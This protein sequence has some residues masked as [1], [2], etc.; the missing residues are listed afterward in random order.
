M[1]V[2][3]VPYNSNKCINQRLHDASGGGSWVSYCGSQP[4][5]NLKLLSQRHLPI[6]AG[7]GTH[8]VSTPL[9]SRLDKPVSRITFV[10]SL[11]E[12]PS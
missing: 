2:L 9:I 3:C 10:F 4:E 11:D 7:Y 5:V 1:R 8:G 12:Q 6:I